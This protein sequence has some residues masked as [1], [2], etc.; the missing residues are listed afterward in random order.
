MT[1]FRLLTK[2]SRKA[3]VFDEG[4]SYFEYVL[5]K[6]EARQQELELVSI[7]ALVRKGTCCGRSMW[8][9]ISVSSGIG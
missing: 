5:K 7:E 2:V 8:Q 3:L 6:S 9:W 1:G 4:L